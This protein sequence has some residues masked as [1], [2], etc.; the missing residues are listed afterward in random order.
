VLRVVGVITDREDGTGDLEKR[1]ERWPPELRKW[2]EDRVEFWS[3]LL[4]GLF[5]MGDA[6]GK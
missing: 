5:L 4:S 3:L 6:F 1:R 2:R